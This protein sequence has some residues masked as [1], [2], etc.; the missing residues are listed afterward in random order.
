MASGLPSWLLPLLSASTQP[1]ALWLGMLSCA[2]PRVA[3]H[4]VQLVFMALEQLYANSCLAACWFCYH[5]KGRCCCATSCCFSTVL[6]YLCMCH[7]W[8]LLGGRLQPYCMPV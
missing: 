7:I 1:V 4:C 5:L 2:K 3:V 6:S 8:H